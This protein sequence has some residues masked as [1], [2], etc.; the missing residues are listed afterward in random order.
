M[1]TLILESILLLVPV[2]STLPQVISSEKV[3]IRINN[4]DAPAG[5]PVRDSKPNEITLIT[6]AISDGDSL[7][8]DKQILYLIGRVSDPED[9]S[10][11]YINA[12]SAKLSAEGLFN[13]Q[14]QLKEGMNEISIMAI[15]K[16]NNLSRLT[17]L[18][19]YSIKFRSA[20]ELGVTGKYY[21]LIIGI[22]RYPSPDIDDL[23]NPV[24]DAKRIYQVL[25]EEYTF[26]RENVKL[27]ENAKYN[28]IIN[29][30]DGYSNLL[31][32]NDNLLIFYAG[33]G[34][35]DE[36]AKLGY[37]FPSDATKE[38]KASWFRNS[39]LQDYLRE[40][41]SNHVLL[42]SDACFSGSIFKSRNALRDAPM[43]VQNLYKL[44]SRK[45]MTSGTLTEVPDESAFVKYL[46]QR[47]VENQEKY[48]PSEVLFSS[49]S[50]AVGN[51]STATP[52]FGEIR[53]TGDE[54]GD[55]IF[56]RKD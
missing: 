51:N 2:I 29:A 40:I 35:W 16:N 12:L 50:I 19:D 44:P 15:D 55:F 39:T 41:R 45:A 33:H 22:D 18:V 23:S 24:R 56:I 25:T 48:L 4:L 1:R 52:Q 20:K 21:A 11:L 31:T 13:E 43:A 9:I 30:L 49:F 54:G 28:D 8:L 47:L 37:W 36:Y 3:T 32:P 46:I 38:S 5:E 6:P 14:Y 42:I 17:F 7:R 53:D 34:F 27:L 26:E 10:S